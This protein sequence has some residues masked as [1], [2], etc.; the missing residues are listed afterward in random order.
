MNLPNSPL[1]THLRTPI[2]SLIEAANTLPSPE[3][4]T[5]R[6]VIGEAV[7]AIQEDDFHLADELL[8]AAGQR[9]NNLTQ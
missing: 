5:I 1:A 7:K 9:I 8:G 6:E 4:E 3:S 2:I